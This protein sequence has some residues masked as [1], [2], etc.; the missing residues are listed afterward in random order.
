MSKTS[1]ESM[2]V[3]GA[4]L[5]FVGIFSSAF[6][7]NRQMVEKNVE[8]LDKINKEAVKQLPDIPKDGNIELEAQGTQYDDRIKIKVKRYRI[9]PI[10]ERSI[11]LDKPSSDSVEKERQNE[12]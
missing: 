12:G 1:V 9:A 8:T 11:E 5:V 3:L 7:G 4:G 10:Q 6:A 2:V